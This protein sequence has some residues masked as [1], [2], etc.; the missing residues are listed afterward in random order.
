LNKEKIFVGKR[1]TVK[2]KMSS[3][4]CLI[5]NPSKARFSRSVS[6]SEVQKCNALH[7]EWWDPRKN[8]LIQMSTVRVQY[9]REQAAAQAFNTNTTKSFWYHQ[10]RHHFVDS[11]DIGCGG[12]VLSESLVRLGA[13]KVTE[14]DPS[15]KD[16]LRVAQQRAET[17]L[18]T[19][20][21][22]QKPN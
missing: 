20:T 14:I 18:A 12:G 22:N 16:L 8:P 11:K 9:I 3:G 7:S 5:Q 15:T 10:C 13:S 1:L 6:E 2:R 21:R 17:L 4:R 19:A